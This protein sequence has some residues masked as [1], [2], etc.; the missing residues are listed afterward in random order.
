MPLPNRIVEPQKLGRKALRPEQNED[1][2]STQLAV[3][4]N[5]VLGALYQ[6]ASLVRH[7]DDLF[8]DLAEECQKVFEK[9]DRIT[10]KLSR[11]KD[12][13]YKL[14]SRKVKIPVGNLKQY[15][16][17]TDHHVARHGF[18]CYM[19]TPDSR[20]H[21]IKDC[22]TL[23]DLTPTK[24]LRGADIYRKDGLCSSNLF[25]LWPIVLNDHK[26]ES[27]QL[28]MLRRDRTGP[29]CNKG[30]KVL[31]MPECRRTIHEFDLEDSNKVEEEGIDYFC[32][33]SVVQ[34][35]TS[36]VGFQRMSSFRDSLRE[37]DAK[38]KKRRRT[39][40]GVPENLLYEIS[41]FERK[42]RNTFDSAPRDRPRA[43]S[44]DDLDAK[45]K[46]ER[47]EI[48]AQYF[49]EI[50]AKYEEMLEEE[51]AQKEPKI[52]KFLPCRRSRSL[53]R[54]VKMSHRSIERF[55]QGSSTGS[56]ASTLSLASEN[57]TGSR[58]SRSTKRSSIISNKI[59][60][61]V[62]AGNARLRQRPKSLD[63][64]AIELCPDNKKK[65]NLR[66]TTSP[67]MPANIEQTTS[68]TDSV[69]G[70]GT[71][72][73]FESNTIPRAQA[74][75]YD[76]PWESLPKDWTTSVKLREINKRKS[77]EERNSS[78]GAWSASGSSSNRQ[79]LD[80]AKSSMPSSTS[81]YSI[82][83]D[84]GRDSPSITDDRPDG[85][86]YSPVQSCPGDD[87]VE[88]VT[89]TK[90]HFTKMDTDAWLQMLA[91]K[92]ASR[93][94]VTSDCA[95]TLKSLSQ[96][97]KQNIQALD[98][99]S[100]ALKP[101]PK[102]DDEVS[103]VYS[104]DQ[105][106]FYTSFHNDS[107][108]RRST[109]TLDED[110][111]KMSPV[112]EAQSMLSMCS[113]NT[114]ESVIYRPRDGEKLA[115]PVSVKKGGKCPP[116][117][118]RRTSSMEVCAK[119]SEND[120]SSSG[121]S[122][123][124]LNNDRSKPGQKG[125]DSSFSE[126][127]QETIYARLKTKT[128]ISSGMYPSWCSVSDEDSTPESSREKL[129]NGHKDVN[130]NASKLS[131]FSRSISQPTSIVMT[132]GQDLSLCNPTM[133]G[134]SGKGED[135][136]L[137]WEGHTLPKRQFSSKMIDDEDFTTNSWP[138]S[139]I[140]KRD[141]SPNG[142][143]PKTLNFAPMINMFDPKSP[144]GVQLP[145]PDMSSSSSDETKTSANSLTSASDDGSFYKLAIPL[146]TPET[147]KKHHGKIPMKYQPII[148]V[149][150]RPRSATDGGQKSGAYVK[151]SPGS[152]PSPPSQVVYP[153]SVI[154]PSTSTPNASKT[155]FRNRSSSCN[156]RVRAHY[157]STDIMS[158]SSGSSSSIPSISS[159]SD[160]GYMDMR[161]ATIKS[162]QSDTLSSNSS[163][164]LSDIDSSSLTY[165][166]MSSA[167][168]TPT[169]ST[170][171]LTQDS[172]SNMSVPEDK[173]SYMTLGQNPVK[174]IKDMAVVNGPTVSSP[175]T[176]SSF[177]GPNTRSFTSSLS[178][179]PTVEAPKMTLHRSSTN[180]Q[181]SCGSQ[182]VSPAAYSS[183]PHSNSRTSSQ[184]H[185]HS[186]SP[187][188][189]TPV[190][191]I[192][193]SQS[194]SVQR[195]SV[196]AVSPLQQS[197]RPKDRRRSAPPLGQ[198]HSS[199]YSQGSPNNA[200]SQ[201]SPNSVFSQGSPSGF[202]SQGSPSN[203]YTQGSPSSVRSA[204]S[205]NS[206]NS[207][208]DS[209]RVAMKTEYDQESPSTPNRAESY[210]VAVT[211]T[212]SAP[213][214][215]EPEVPNRA[216]SYRFAV[217]NTNGLVDSSHKRNTSYRV[218]LHEGE[219][220]SRLDAL[221]SW[222]GS[223]K[224]LRRMCITDIDQLKCYSDDDSTKKTKEKSGGG[225][226]ATINSSKKKMSSKS[227]IESSLR[228][229][230]TPSPD[231]GSKRSSKADK[232]KDKKNAKTRS[233]TYIR[234]DPIFEDKEDFFNSSSDTLRAQ[235]VS[236]LRPLSASHSSETLTTEEGPL[237]A[238]RL[239]SPGPVGKHKGSNGKK[240]VDERAV[241]SIL[242][243]IKSTIKSISG[244]GPDKED[245]HYVAQKYAA[246]I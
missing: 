182:G 201:G 83:K 168:S 223:G 113:T 243:S 11:V 140:L 59:K 74:K 164:A 206:A 1:P 153:T 192:P 165:V 216:D 210:R 50:D 73:Y 126:S 197:Q 180:P 156:N 19:F 22:Y 17:V 146:G 144:Q 133:V 219:R 121:G 107:G 189:S 105:E 207:R 78:S 46:T 214:A 157:A 161:L 96:L 14:D 229:N 195:P 40:S 209:Y 179:S 33:P 87:D 55:Q 72:Y 227:D 18:D 125:L 163:I 234:F 58:F 142:K 129:M 224:D 102:L 106:G 61:L 236:S 64:D 128:R 112:K 135:M 86:K 241:M 35:D 90:S 150:P 211:K 218:T 37:S 132:A 130:G 98:L 29:S 149:K 95:D 193:P 220:D 199:F 138:R 77:M 42:K 66:K 198:S 20:P 7:A 217:R 53:P 28:S 177:N 200:Y 240:P 111:D 120:S 89:G 173:D 188:Q 48:L 183:I 208:S 237:L 235:S 54:C 118:P 109:A 242:D 148:T 205:Q 169:N 26:V 12:Y 238:K 139:G 13:V 92:A 171:T 63:L 123:S 36:G 94:D 25:K 56:Y 174:S 100:P 222:N 152:Q 145:L 202:Y 99:M 103:S 43:Y 170:L 185:R 244:R 71:Y 85:L 151:L 45:T 137:D 147:V 84:S 93:D 38:K 239:Q 101:P 15:S 136:N 230:K 131:P 181:I 232:E 91:M 134:L 203:A 88:S 226:F 155:P 49:D 186:L 194:S 65:T 143:T 225:I 4:H 141:K 116:P 190:N 246:D 68:S 175:P 81:Q 108:L 34:I 104:L 231:S 5:T 10:E 31:K 16:K 32:E 184:S 159:S 114:V 124:T 67:S 24:I 9:T 3:S 233:S 191:H 213:P 167:N 117:P 122:T 82:G 245:N 176:F 80:S 119:I 110:V 162:N 158:Q 215:V 166:S 23:A 2:V 27:P 221:N 160:G 21:C 172:G 47:D 115:S 62:S 79:S 8:C 70:P 127:D 154:K 212:N 57:S 69:V 178:P 204:D 75:K 6:L 51:T 52:L 196:L 76:F 187:H 30:Y 44:F 39:V 97:T 228:P 60:S 41:E